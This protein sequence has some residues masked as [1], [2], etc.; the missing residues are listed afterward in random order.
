LPESDLALL[1]QAALAAGEIAQK[2]WQKSPEIWEK[3]DDAG[4][5][6]EADLAVNRMLL[7]DL[8]GARPDYGW[9]SEESDD[10][11]ERLTA[12]RLFVVDPIDGTRAFIEGA[13]GFAH[14]LAVVEQGVVTAGVVYLPMLDKLYT[15]TLGGGAKLNGVSIVASNP[16]TEDVAS[17]LSAR[18]NLEPQHWP[19]G[20]P[21]V[22]RQFQSS[23]A[24][25]LAL[26]GEGSFDAMLTL[27]DSWEWDIAAGA[28][29]ATEAGARVTDRRDQPLKFN[30][31][32]PKV[33][34]V[35]ASGPHLHAQLMSRLT[36][37]ASAA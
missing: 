27:R 9:L 17:L 23:L 4:P 18:P 15:A 25:R 37:P 33:P 11:A 22:D 36:G 26:V 14:A 29:I 3:S 7:A 30:N 8:I 16:V 13:R 19:G 12:T 6:T 2:Y 32:L 5:V 35:L 10:N 24:Y 20:V 21:P 1:T 28:L 34:G 31:P